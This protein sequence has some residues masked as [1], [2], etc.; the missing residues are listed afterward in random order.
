MNNLVLSGMVDQ[1]RS[2]GTQFESDRKANSTSSDK[3]TCFLLRLDESGW[4]LYTA[5]DYV[6]ESFKLPVE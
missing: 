4:K 1:A 5:W 3:M 6:T 2:I